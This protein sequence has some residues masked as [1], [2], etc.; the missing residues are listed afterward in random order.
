[1][2]TDTPRMRPAPSRRR[3]AHARSRIR[4][5]AL[6]ALAFL[7]MQTA[8]RAQSLTVDRTIGDFTSAVSLSVNASGELIVLDA[9]ANALVRFDGD[10]RELSRIQ[11]TGWGAQEFDG[12]TDVSASFP[13]AVFVAD[14]RNMRVQQFD[15]DLQHVQTIGEPR[16]AEGLGLGGS[17]RPAATIQSAQGD[18][19][20]L[21]ADGMRV[22]K[23]TPRFR[24]EREFGTYASGDGRL[25]A[26]TDICIMGD[27]RVA[28]A[29]GRSVVLF[30]QFG[31]YVS[32][33]GVTGDEQILALSSGGNDVV[34]V[35]ADAITVLPLGADRAG[36]TV[37]MEAGSIVGEA[38]DTLRDA[39]RTREW[40]YV[41]TP[42]TLLVCRRSE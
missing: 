14:G 32:R 24:V 6:I 10:G 22:V 30:D 29:D 3:A 18:L 13:L 21:D 31:N 26:P 5:F 9:G 7:L 1:M 35:S 19:F 4:R 15:R 8:A 33:A 2:T 16:T 25:H 17:F 12:P 23:M 20:V 39:V 28:V 38:V 41:L 36:G 37:R 34:C 11:G 27:G 42:R 40:W